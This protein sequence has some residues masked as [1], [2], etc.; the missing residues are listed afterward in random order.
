[1]PKEFVVKYGKDTYKRN[2]LNRESQE[3]LGAELLPKIIGFGT[4]INTLVNRQFIENENHYSIYQCIKDI[5]NADD[6][7]WL[8]DAVLY[9]FENPIC[10]GNRY[11]A[12]EEEVDEHFSGDYIRKIAVTLQ[13]AYQNLGELKDLIG[14][15][16]G[17]TENI[18]SYFGKVVEKYVNQ[19]EQSLNIY[20]ANLEKEKKGTKK[21]GKKS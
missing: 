13:F 8:I 12:S 19:A 6:V 15:L 9:D 2:A 11:L 21:Q 16:S 10:V 17:L 7:R 20:E 3:R 4:T 18:V 5:F 14:N 1:M